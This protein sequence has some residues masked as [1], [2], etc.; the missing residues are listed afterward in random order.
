MINFR[1]LVENLLLTEA[2]GFVSTNADFK[3]L[4]Q[5]MKAKFDGFNEGPEPS[6]FDAFKTIVQQRGFTRT[7][8]GAIADPFMSSYFPL[9]DLL[10]LVNEKYKQNT[11][12]TIN[13][14][15]DDKFPE[16]SPD[17]LKAFEDVK[18]A[19]KSNLSNFTGPG[20][21]PIAG[22]TNPISGTMKGFYKQVL[23]NYLES[24]VIGKKALENFVKNGYTLIQAITHIANMRKDTRT[25]FT[26]TK[27]L[28]FIDNDVKSFFWRAEDY[29]PGAARSPKQIPARL[30]TIPSKDLFILADLIKT[31]ALIK[32][33]PPSVTTTSVPD[34]KQE[35]ENQR[36][37]IDSILNKKVSE[38]AADKSTPE[39]AQIIAQ[40]TTQAD[41]VPGKK[42]YAG[43]QS[44]LADIASAASGGVQFG[45]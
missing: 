1:Q 7:A 43:L 24:G 33:P 13:M 17:I 11:S 41:H 4:M 2:A 18:G 21:D 25:I 10:C 38:I 14:N 39:A 16:T 26:R 28:P 40:L 34:P 42:D 27:I 35:A 3:Q 22:Y 9:V 29:I 15:F 37:S 23:D 19:F 36:K 30:K 8:P 45:R 32:N 6:Q 20:L 12:R 31:Y 44:G 5:D